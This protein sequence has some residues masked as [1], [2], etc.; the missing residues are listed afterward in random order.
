M[1]TLF[2]LIFS[3]VMNYFY[4]FLAA[5]AIIVYLI[6]RYDA[7]NKRKVSAIL[8]ANKNVPPLF[9]LRSA[10]IKVSAIKAVVNNHAYNNADIEIAKYEISRQLDKLMA[11]YKNREI[12]LATYY[13]KIGA[14]LITANKLKATIASSAVH[15][16]V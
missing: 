12:P 3:S 13:A 5:G 7:H 6:I 14:L 8:R 16:N 4:L 15:V 10:E 9:M 2:N 11:D 1:A